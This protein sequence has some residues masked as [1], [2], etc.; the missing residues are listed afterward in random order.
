MYIVD[1]T[2]NLPFE[3]FVKDKT[4]ITIQIYPILFVVLNPLI[5]GGHCFLKQF[6]IFFFLKITLKFH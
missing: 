5:K 4:A 2:M 1:R 3:L 6:F